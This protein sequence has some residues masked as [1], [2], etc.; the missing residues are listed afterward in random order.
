[1]AQSSMTSVSFVIPH[2]VSRFLLVYAFESKMNSSCKADVFYDYTSIKEREKQQLYF[3]EEAVVQRNWHD[4]NNYCKSRNG[5]LASFSSINQFHDILEHMLHTGIAGY[6][7]LKLNISQVFL[8]H[9][10]SMLRT[11]LVYN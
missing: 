9:C 10:N 2:S 8:V 1:M 7:G 3:Y 5:E 6:I 4:A 11:I